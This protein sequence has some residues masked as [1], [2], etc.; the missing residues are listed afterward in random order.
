M[1]DV[2]SSIA[3]VRSRTFASLIDSSDYRKFFLGQGISLV[4]TWLQDA[5][6]SWIVFDMTRSESTLGVVSAAG[7]LPG[8]FVG[9]YAG[10]VADRVVPK[11]MILS[12]QVAQMLCAFALMAL[13]GSGSARIWQMAAILALTRVC[14]TFEMP[15]RN[16]FL[17]D[18][19]GKASLMNAIALNSGL[20]NASKVIGPAL[21][22][23]C[24]A[25][26][27][28]TACFG[29]N[30]LSYLAAIA[31]LLMIHRPHKALPPGDGGRGAWHGGLSYLM[32]DRALRGH[33]AGLILF[34]VVGM[35][36]SA[37]V[38]AY[39][40]QVVRVGPFGYSVLLAGAGLG[41][42]L[43]ALALASMGG[44]R[45]KSVLVGAGMAIF[46]VS[47]AVSGAAPPWLLRHG[48]PDAALS[49]ATLGMSGAGFGALMFYASTQTLIQTSVPD[50][51]RGRIMGVW[52]ISFSGSVPLGSIASGWM[53]QRFG[54]A[55]V[56]V[57]SSLICLVVAVAS[58]SRR[59]RLAQA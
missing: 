30:G 10:A 3:P 50:D 59:G 58:L 20:F 14:V 11:T 16:V 8:L 57:G 21:A 49:A 6:V 9:L 1:P 46:A 47:L 53:A 54:V 55:T 26:F 24:L 48:H 23:A 51:L 27:G 39:A 13:V 42:T 44:L 38:P 4:G 22:G 5:A 25:W 34:G 29:L 41:A 37:L 32:T 2:A 31:S 28:R 56:M 45:N 18:I 33:F 12:M 35:G 7:T 43:G 36:Y 15:S 40:R 19:V 17:Y 52:M